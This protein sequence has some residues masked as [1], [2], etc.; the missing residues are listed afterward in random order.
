MSLCHYKKGINRNIQ[1]EE[2]ILFAQY[3]LQYQERFIRFVVPETLVLGN[4]V[5][6]AD[7]EQVFQD[8]QC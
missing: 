1:E 4:E 8:G 6:W 5:S 2:A 7:V 3:V